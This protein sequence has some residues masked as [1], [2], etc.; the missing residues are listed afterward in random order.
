MVMGFARRILLAGAISAATSANAISLSPVKLDLPAG[1]RAVALGVTNDSMSPR[2][3]DVRILKWVSTSGDGT[4]DSTSAVITARPVINIPPGQTATIRVA[5]LQR[6]AAPADYYRVFVEDITP[7]SQASESVR[8]RYSLPM[9]VMNSRLAKGSLQRVDG[10]LINS[11]TAAVFV[12][13]VKKDGTSD[14]FRYLLPG[15]RWETK[16][17]PEDLDW[18]SGIQ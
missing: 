16:F 4:F 6:S 5:V 12:A 1:Q 14:V 17:L 11:G 7:V 15:E 10:A 3:Y 18:T 13:G 8:M 9:Q 2:T